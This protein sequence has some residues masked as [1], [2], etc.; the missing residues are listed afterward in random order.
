MKCTVF[1]RAGY[2]I[3]QREYTDEGF[4]KVP[5]RVARTGIQE[6]LARELHS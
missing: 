2:R 6:Y 3:T 4:L 5:G 1:D